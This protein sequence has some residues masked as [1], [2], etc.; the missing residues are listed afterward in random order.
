MSD[1][2]TLAV[3]PTPQHELFGKPA[4]RNSFTTPHSQRQF[5]TNHAEIRL[6]AF[7]HRQIVVRWQSW[8]TCD[9]QVEHSVVPL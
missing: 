6:A 2:N 3:M 7:R 8:P 1:R 9:A 5:L 4:A